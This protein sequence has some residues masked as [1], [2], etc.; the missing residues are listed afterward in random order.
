MSGKTSFSIKIDVQNAG[1]FEEIKSR[2]LDLTPAFE[3]FVKAWAKNNKDMFDASEGQE[4][5]GATVDPD[6]FW[7]PLSA[8]YRKAKRREGYPDHLMVATGDLMR[9]LTDPNLIFKAIGPQ[10]AVFGIPKDLD[11]ANKVKWNARRRQ[12]VFFKAPGPDQNALKR[13]VKDYLTL[14]GDFEAMRAAQ[15]L[16]AVRMRSEASAMDLDFANTVGPNTGDW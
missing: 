15:G 11:E 3:A 12:T 7:Q 2:F 16:E 8:A 4:A 10:D 9:A 5:E 1:A 6:V 13:I 14:G